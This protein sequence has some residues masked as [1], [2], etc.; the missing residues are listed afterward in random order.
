MVG[1]RLQDACKSSMSGRRTPHSLD[2]G[3]P[4]QAGFCV[5]ARQKRERLADICWPDWLGQE[6]AGLVSSWF[7]RTEGPGGEDT[8]TSG[9]A[10][11]GSSF[12]M[13]LS[14]WFCSFGSPGPTRI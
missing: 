6:V 1:D 11:P 5:R 12:L 13:F 8:P 7:Q 9:S 14:D 3:E 2:R 4:W 10:Y